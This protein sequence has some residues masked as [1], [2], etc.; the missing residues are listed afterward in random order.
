[1]IVEVDVPVLPGSAVKLQGTLF[2]YD[3]DGTM[4]TWPS[5]R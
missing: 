1:M 2:V 4:W 5:E 3:G